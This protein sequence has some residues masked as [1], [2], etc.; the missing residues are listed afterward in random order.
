M[1]W[2]EF[3]RGL[4]AQKLHFY[5]EK[6]QDNLKILADS[7]PQCIRIVFV[8]EAGSR[9]QSQF[10]ST[11]MVPGY[12]HMST[13]I[14]RK[15]DGFLSSKQAFNIQVLKNLRLTGVKKTNSLTL[16]QQ[17]PVDR[18]PRQRRGPGPRPRRPR[19]PHRVGCRLGGP[20]GP[21]AAC[22]GTQERPSAQP[23]AATRLDR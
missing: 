2:K 4:Q 12:R 20:P 17:V 5:K 10:R 1:S 3:Q 18:P 7:G 8:S 22:S 6:K 21:A 23:D 11:T 9:S 19:W 13:K 15:S 16:W 14:Q